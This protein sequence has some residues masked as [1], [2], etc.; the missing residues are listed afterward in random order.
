MFALP[1][2]AHGQSSVNSVIYATGAPSSGQC[3]TSLARLEYRDTS[4][5]TPYFCN[6]SGAWET[7]VFRALTALSLTGTG[8]ATNTFIGSGTASNTDMA[9]VLAVS[10]TTTASY[11]FQR[12]PAY[13]SHPI[14]TALAEGTTALP[15][16]VSYTG[17]ASVTFTF[18]TFTGNVAYI[19][20]A[21]N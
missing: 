18:A 19:C 8:S 20:V 14:C 4:T 10:G 9:G 2:L 11:T 1:V 7:G 16:S 17:V 13:A 15:M 12:S 5:G 6:T 21:R 3:T